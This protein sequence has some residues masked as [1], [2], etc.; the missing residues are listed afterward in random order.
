MQYKKAKGKEK[1]LRG[2]ESSIAIH[3]AAVKTL[4]AARNDGKQGFF[5]LSF[6]N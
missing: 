5:S 2:N 6:L 4:Q 3:E 1:F